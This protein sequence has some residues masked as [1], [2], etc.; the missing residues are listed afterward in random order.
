MR[1][2]KL[3]DFYSQK[4]VSL[5]TLE[6]KVERAGSSKTVQRRIATRC[7]SE[8]A[9]KARLENKDYCDGVV[10]I[11]LMDTNDGLK[12]PLVKEFKE[13]VGDYI[14]TFP[15][16][17][18]ENDEDLRVTAIRELK[19][20]TGL[21]AEIS[22]VI[23]QKPT[24]TSVGII[25]QKVALAIL[26]CSG[27]PTDKY[28]SPSEDIKAKLFTLSEIEELIKSDEE[29]AGNTRI[30]LGLILAT[31]GDIDKLRELL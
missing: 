18:T 30:S 6:F 29:I 20:E 9:F 11:G 16:G 4:G 25:D 26:K 7:K 19:E 28:L 31:N 1:E 27:T 3:V 8:E 15:A 17:Q 21:D 10:I 2:V 5:A 14:W 12:V 13:L 24:Y 22:N 23:V